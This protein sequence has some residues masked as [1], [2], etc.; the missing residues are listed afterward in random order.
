M[1]ALFRPFVCL[2][3]VLIASADAT[4]AT[5]PS[6]SATQIAPV[7]K[8]DEYEGPA[9]VVENWTKPHSGWLYILDPRPSPGEIGGHI[10]LVDPQA[11]EVM[12]SIRTASHPDFAL[13]PDGS[14]LY[15][16][17]NIDLHSTVLAAVDTSSGSVL[18][19]GATIPDRAMPANIIPSYSAMAVSGDGRFLR[20]L[21][22]KPN[23]VEFKLDAIDTRTGDVMPNHVDV[24]H[25]GDGQFISFPTAD[26][27]N[28]V[29][30][31]MKKVRLVRTGANSKE[32]EDTNTEFPW[33]HRFGV[34]TAFP[35]PDGQY[36]TIV[37]CDG[38]VFEM[39]VVNLGFYPT[40]AHAGQPQRI[41]PSAWPR[42][43]DGSRVYLGYGHS[44]NTGAGNVAAYEFRVYNTATWRKPRTIKTSVPFWSAVIS[45]DGKYLYALA[46]EQ[47]SI[48]VIDTSV[49]RQIRTINVGSMPSLGLVAP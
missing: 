49:M 36:I 41:F 27:V 6:S 35:S 16:A 13:S 34:A 2:L 43:P 32:L 14:Y 20:L 3:L 17:S 30:P 12:G 28:F 15:I 5:E 21:V 11:G 10:W 9:V 18:F 24:K 40:S 44:P 39:N 26:E 25:C 33:N 42:S 45:G 1:K 8:T 37:R 23:S 46:P 38:A 29:C 19:G 7:A 31:A 47:H 4:V 48:L 22:K